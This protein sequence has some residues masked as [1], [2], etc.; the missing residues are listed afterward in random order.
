MSALLVWPNDKRSKLCL[1][2]L[3]ARVGTVTYVNKVTKLGWVDFFVLGCNQQRCN[4]NQL[5]FRPSDFPP[6]EVAVDEINRQ[7]ERFRN[8]LELQVYLDKP[9]NEYG[10]HAFV[11]VGLILHIDRSD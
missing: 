9:I 10:P 3:V 4:P 5:Q 7:V 11:Y 8:K 1:T 6:L 2:Y